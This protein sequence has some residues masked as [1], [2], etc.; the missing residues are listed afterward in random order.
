MVECDMNGIVR[1]TGHTPVGQAINNK[2]KAKK[3]A[4]PAAFSKYKFYLDIKVSKIRSK[5]VEDISSLGGV[6]YLLY[7]TL[8]ICY[9][10][11]TE[12]EIR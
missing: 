2:K 4:Y 12:V 6:S 5:L 11:T 1:T 9:S 3:I 8:F 7:Y 10:K